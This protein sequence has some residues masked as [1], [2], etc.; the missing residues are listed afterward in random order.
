MEAGKLT[1]Q[2][3]PFEFHEV[4]KRILFPFRSLSNPN[5]EIVADYDPRIDAFSPV[6][7]GDDQRLT[8]VI[9]NLISNACKFTPSGLIT[10]RTKLIHPTASGPDIELHLPTTKT[11]IND[12]SP[13]R[14]SI[15]SSRH[16]QD[17][18]RQTVLPKS[19]QDIAIIRIEVEDTGVGIRPRDLI[20]NRLFSPYIQ[21]CELSISTKEVCLIRLI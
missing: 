13:T 5:L 10:V 7:L 1:V 3:K 18:Q 4:F 11:T 16:S 20:D 8:Q 15:S 12:E 17:E 9:G 6:Y 14:P 21:V 19:D 2:S